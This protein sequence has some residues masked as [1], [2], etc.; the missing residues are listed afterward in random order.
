M[1]AQFRLLVAREKI[2]LKTRSIRP[3]LAVDN[4]HVSQVPSPYLGKIW[5]EEVGEYLDGAWLECLVD[6]TEY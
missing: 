1:F 3:I 2:D 5:G 6:F 4:F